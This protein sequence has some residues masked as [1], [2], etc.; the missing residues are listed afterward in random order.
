MGELFLLTD[1]R[2]L[3]EQLFHNGIA[4]CRRFGGHAQVDAAQRGRPDE[5]RHRSA[6]L[7]RY[8]DRFLAKNR[9]VW[10]F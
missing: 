8:F 3:D 10:K 4:S 6:V 7:C 9:F 5:K 1:G 2:H